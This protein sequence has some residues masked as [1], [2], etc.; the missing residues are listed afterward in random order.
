M[1]PFAL[2]AINRFQY[3]N[4]IARHPLDKHDP[5]GT[6]IRCMRWV[7][8]SRLSAGAIAV[9]YING[10][11]MLM[12][13]GMRG[14]TENIYTGLSEFVDM[15]FLLHFLRAEDL[16]IDIGA[17]VGA[18]TVLA[19][20][21]A[22]AHCIALEPAPLTYGHLRDN[23]ALNAIEG[24]VELRNVA[25]G[26]QNGFVAFTRSLDTLNHVVREAGNDD[27]IEVKMETLDDIVG[28]RKPIL[29]RLTLKASRSS[30]LRVQREHLRPTLSWA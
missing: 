20:A 15:S 2:R 22:G 1:R 27:V 29:S 7:V 25:V 18:Y 3:I 5:V 13:R 23:V 9:P 11:R 14:A 26:D 10:S 4:E 12:S 19:S 8:S 24:L 6:F 28:T 17:N 30:Y 21:V 16:F